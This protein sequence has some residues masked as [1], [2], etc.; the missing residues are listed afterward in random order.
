MP[1]SEPLDRTDQRWTRGTGSVL[2]DNKYDVWA[3]RAIPE[4]FGIVGAHPKG[5][6]KFGAIAVVQVPPTKA[7]ETRRNEIKM[8]HSTRAMMCV[9]CLARHGFRDMMCVP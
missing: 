7:F 6:Q 1:Y 4:L 9:P 3:E 8:V 2:L 5:Q